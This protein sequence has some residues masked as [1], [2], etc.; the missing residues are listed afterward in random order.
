[1]G[2]DDCHDD[3]KRYPYRIGNKDIGWGTIEI[4]GCEVHAT[5]T[6]NMLNLLEPE[7]T[8]KYISMKEGI[9]RHRKQQEGFN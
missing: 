1:M 4:V 8:R 2:C 5:Y 3:P 6:L 9:E 7:Y